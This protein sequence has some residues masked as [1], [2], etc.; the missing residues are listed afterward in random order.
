MPTDTPWAAWVAPAFA[1][2]APDYGEQLAR[3]VATTTGP[4]QYD[5]RTG[6]LSVDLPNGWE[7]FCTPDWD[8]APNTLSWDVHDGDYEPHGHGTLSVQWSRDLVQ[9]AVTYRLMLWALVAALTA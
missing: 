5:R 3:Y 7:F 6:C 2:G 9:D 8:G 4:V 1:P